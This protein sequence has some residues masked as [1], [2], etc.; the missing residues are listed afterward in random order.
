MNKISALMS[1]MREPVASL[2]PHCH[3]RTQREV[4][5]LQ[6]RRGPSPELDHSGTLMLYF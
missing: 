3:V 2:S 4:S 5:S 6:P 1:V